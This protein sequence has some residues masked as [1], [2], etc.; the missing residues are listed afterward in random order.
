MDPAKRKGK[1]FGRLAPVWLLWQDAKLFASELARFIF[2]KLHISFSKFESGKGKFAAV[3]YKGRGK[4]ARRLIHGGMAGLTTLG[5][6]I[7][8][9][10]A[11]EFPGT[12]LDPWELPD[13]SAVLS[14]TTDSTNTLISDKVRAEI[15]DYEVQEG[16]TLGSIA[17]KFG[18][19]QETLLWQNSLTKTS[20]IK[21]GQTI[22][23]LPVTGVAYKVKKGD[24]VQSI[25]KA[26][27]SSA[28]AIVDFPYNTFT[29][30]ETFEL[31]IGQTVIVPEGVPAATVSTSAP[32][33]KQITPDAGTVVA[34]GSFVWPTQ[35]TISQ[36]YAWYHGGI[37]IA[38][39]GL[40][41]I[42]AA[43]S[44]TVV[45]AGW[46]NV[47]YGNYVVIDHGNGYR[48]LYAHMSAIYVVAGQTV[49]RGSSI[50]KMGSTG[51]STGPH[52]HFEVIRNGVH[53]N[54]FSVLQ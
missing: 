48:T 14:A 43:D 11:Q 32:R 52:L 1:R 41:T 46:S 7:A 31:A 37:D 40:P 54:P 8:P 24:T 26:H 47:G 50:G 29:N 44:G 22:Q 36:N 15:V 18:V 4:M 38:N 13:T 27:D 45:T 5:M 12:S 42:L 39:R 6:M 25:A 3:L 23:V 51:R 20:K 17:D 35:G 19:S 33:I 53:M 30:D 9:A 2:G 28:Q 49:G 34:S 16:D 10:I 21:P